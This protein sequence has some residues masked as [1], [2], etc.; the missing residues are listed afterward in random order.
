MQ[1]ISESCVD[2]ASPSSS[3][4]LTSD[5]AVYTVRNRPYDFR[6]GATPYLDLDRIEYD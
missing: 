1:V 2:Y 5:M 3:F 4:N 6:I